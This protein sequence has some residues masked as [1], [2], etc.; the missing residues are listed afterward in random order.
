MQAIVKSAGGTGLL[1]L[2][3]ISLLLWA[4]GTYGN[5]TPA[6][7]ATGPWAV[8]PPTRHFI[9]H[10]GMSLH[11]VGYHIA[12]PEDVQDTQTSPP[13]LTPAQVFRNGGIQRLDEN[14][15]P[16]LLNVSTDLDEV[17][18]LAANRPSGQ[19]QGAW[20]YR[21]ATGPHMINLASN[22]YGGQG[23]R[24]YWTVGALLWSQIIAFAVTTGSDSAEDL[25]WQSNHEYDRAW[26]AF[27]ASPWQPLFGALGPVRREQAR[28]F[29]E[30]ASDDTDPYGE[31]L[32]E[33][34]TD[35]NPMLDVQ[36]RLVLRALLDWDRSQFP[37]RDFPLASVQRRMYIY[38]PVLRQDGRTGQS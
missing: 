14:R 6:V 29:Y 35:A 38:N 5:E 12:L 26:E 30:F 13:T 22:V 24:H 33:L 20:V 32:D 8:G 1:S 9:F 11:D 23:P 18:R 19:P 15:L 34:T 25:V 31:F 36:S 21:V 28:T 10:H 37:D 17:L 7:P 2:I 27:G 3:W 4:K 16:D